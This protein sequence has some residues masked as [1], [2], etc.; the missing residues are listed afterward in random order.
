MSKAPDLYAC[1]LCGLVNDSVA[2]FSTDDLPGTHSVPLCEKHQK[3]AFKFFVDMLLF[4]AVGE[5]QTEESARKMWDR[6]TALAKKNH[7]TA[8]YAQELLIA[9]TKR[10]GKKIDILQ[11]G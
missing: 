1:R 7:I 3:E 6:V 8:D 2:L 11:K 10:M 9:R 5:K 4:G